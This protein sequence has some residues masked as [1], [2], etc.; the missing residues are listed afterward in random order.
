VVVAPALTRR[1]AVVAFALAAHAAGSLAAGGDAW[2][3]DARCRDGRPQGPYRLRDA[4]GQLRVAGAFDQGVRTGSFFFWRGNG[5]RA[6]QVPYDDNG[7][8]NGT[9]ATWYDAA[10]AREP[11]MRFESQWRQGIREGETR[12][13]Y[14]DGHPRTRADYAAGRI[15]RADAWNEDGTALASAEARALALRDAAEADADAARRDALIGEHMPR[16]E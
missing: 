9:L 1:L 15:L 10:P 13:W 14:V 5:V 16:C 7:N 6:A 2:V 11:V 3:L 12:S 4:H 8:V